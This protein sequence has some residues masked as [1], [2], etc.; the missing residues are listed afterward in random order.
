MDP[1]G[2]YELTAV[3]VGDWVICEQQQAGWAQSAPSN[4]KCEAIDADAPG[5]HEVEVTQGQVVADKD[6]GNSE[7]SI[8]SG[9]KFDD[10][11][12]DGVWD[13]DGA[14][15]APGGGDDEVGLEGWTIEAYTDDGNGT[16]SDTEAGV[17]PAGSTTTVGDGSYELQLPPGTYVICEQLMAGW[18]QSLP[19]SPNKK[20]GEVAGA[21]PGGY[22][23]DLSPGEELK[24]QDFGNFRSGGVNGFKVD[25]CNLDGLPDRDGPDHDLDTLGDNEPV[26]QGW[27]IGAYAPDVNGDATGSPVDTDVT[28]PK[29]FYELTVPLGNWVICEQL[30]SGWA[31]SAPD[32]ADE[33][34]QRS[35]RTLRAAMKSPSPRATSKPTGTSA[36]TARP[37]SPST[38]STRTAPPRRRWT[39]G[40]SA[41]MASTTRMSPTAR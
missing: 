12:Y 10:A 28:D 2:F 29:G 27:T 13:P 30:M 32:P 7:S 34:A 4:T 39:S 31:Q 36:T 8:V 21:A 41:R 15:D 17:A 5:G 22:P 25:D 3:P 11:N 37:R 35:T 38:R 6:F 9:S 23:A 18:T 14:D 19:A 1:K 24:D 40:S 26:L 16:L 33:G 20:C